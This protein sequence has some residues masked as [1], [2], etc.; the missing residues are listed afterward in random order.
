MNSIKEN[1]RYE[2]RV[3]IENQIV[4]KTT[5]RNLNNL[6]IKLS[7]KCDLEHS[8]AKGEIVEIAT[9]KVVYRCRKVTVIDK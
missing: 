4:F 8:G 9:G 2:A 1:K 5:G 6:K 3:K 7:E